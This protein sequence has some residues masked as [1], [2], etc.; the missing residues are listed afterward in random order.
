VLMPL[1]ALLASGC[2]IARPRDAPLMGEALMV[3][4][5]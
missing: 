2:D 3:R 1:V 5:E 4:P